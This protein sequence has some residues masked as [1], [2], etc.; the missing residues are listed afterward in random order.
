MKEYKKTAPN[1]YIDCTTDLYYAVLP[2]I[3][4]IYENNEI[5]KKYFKGK[6]EKEKDAQED[7]DMK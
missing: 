4:E 7:I 3:M 5:W 2:R 1:N 6:S